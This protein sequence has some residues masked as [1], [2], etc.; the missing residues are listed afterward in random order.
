MKGC[1]G[2]GK[3][4]VLRVKREVLHTFTVVTVGVDSLQ[5]SRLLPHTV[6]HPCFICGG[7]KTR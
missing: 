6:C 7:S 1:I 5:R 2:K 4:L 3:D